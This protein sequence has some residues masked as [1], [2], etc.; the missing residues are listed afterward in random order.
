M[1]IEVKEQTLQTQKLNKNS[2]THIGSKDKEP[3]ENST[4]MSQRQLNSIERHSSAG[5]ASGLI[6][7]SLSLR[8]NEMR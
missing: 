3:T 1:L 8:A 7:Q 2:N 6:S 4:A 5:H